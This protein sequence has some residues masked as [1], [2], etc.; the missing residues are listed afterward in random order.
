MRKKI[1]AFMPYVI[2]LAVIFYALPLL[3][4][5]TG[6]GMFLMLL[7]IP[8]LTFACSAIYGKLQGFNIFFTFI[9]VILFA[10]TIYIFYNSSASIYIVVYGIV[11]LVGNLIGMLFYKNK[12][13]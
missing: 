13:N 1:F 3:I 11:S 6:S 7:I 2:V 12:N 8:L 5:D 9:T 4:S 10:P